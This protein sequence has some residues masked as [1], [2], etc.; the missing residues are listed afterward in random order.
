MKIVIFSE[1]SVVKCAIESE[2]DPVSDIRFNF[3]MTLDRKAYA[4]LAANHLSASMRDVIKAIKEDAYN[5]GYRDG[6]QKR[7]KV[8]HFSS[9]IQP[10]TEV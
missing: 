5:A 8:N 2:R 7:R 9:A 3:V 1:G 4:S 6:R 10:D